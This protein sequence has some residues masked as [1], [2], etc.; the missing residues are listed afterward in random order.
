MVLL[1][2]QISSSSSYLSK[3]PDS[4][5]LVPRKSFGKSVIFSEPVGF[6]M[7]TSFSFKTAKA[8]FL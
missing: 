4:C 7:N 1:P 8:Q 3:E 5:N 2:V 6:A